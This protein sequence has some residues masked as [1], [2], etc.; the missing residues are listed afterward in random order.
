MSTMPRH[1][2]KMTA[3]CEITQ[4]WVGEHAR[5]QGIGTMLLE[6]AEEEAKSKVCVT[7]LVKSYSF[8]APQFYERNGYR[9]EHILDGFPE[10]RAHYTLTKSI[11]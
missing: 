7:I 9:I 1:S 10:E 11:G 4:L 5:N 2:T 8:Q 6:A 3:A